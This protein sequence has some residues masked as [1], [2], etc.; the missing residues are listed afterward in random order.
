ML[1]AIGTEFE[2]AG[3]GDVQIGALMKTTTVKIPPTFVAQAVSECC[4]L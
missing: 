1:K 4:G 3:A 2:E